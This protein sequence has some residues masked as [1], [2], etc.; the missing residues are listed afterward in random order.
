MAD[1]PEIKHI[2][3]AEDE[4]C[5][6]LEAMRAY[7]DGKLSAAARHQVERHLL[8]CE[9]CSLAIEGIADQ[10]DEVIEAGAA[11]IS[12]EAW[13]RVQ[14]KSKRRV[15]Y[16]WLSAAASV[17]LLVAV[18]W[19]LLAPP[20]DAKMQEVFSEMIEA[21]KAEDSVLNQDIAQARPLEGATTEDL[22]SES[23]P[24]SEAPLPPVPAEPK[25]NTLTL[26]QKVQQD[27]PVS[28]GKEMA[29]GSTANTYKLSEGPGTTKDAIQYSAAP[30]AKPTISRS[31][32]VDEAVISSAEQEESANDLDGTVFISDDAVQRDRKSLE[33]KAIPSNTIEKRSVAERQKPKAIPSK[34]S[35]GVA[36]NPAPGSTAVVVAN[37][38]KEEDAQLGDAPDLEAITIGAA[39]A[40]RVAMDSMSMNLAYPKSSFDQGMEAYGRQDF[41]N[42]ATQLRAAAAQTPSNFQ[43]H[44]YAATSFLNIGQPE[45]A[46]F[47]LDRILAQAP[48]AYTEDA[49]WYKALAYLKMND[50]ATAKKQLTKV[51]DAKGKH[52]A[53]AKSSLEKL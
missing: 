30:V 41:V 1:A 39:S 49:E 26:P 23:Q 34:K 21:S 25:P 22:P 18:G 20:S 32:S 17:M 12:I 5:L 44:L 15:A 2:F 31:I 35:A 10:S 19:A 45:A 52:S 51:K 43:A 47:H 24:V 46:L 16:I 53:K 13:G 36:K 50:A 48:N 29:K 37:Q 9:L 3:S 27:V 4:D 11:S 40:P 14:A 8:N 28:A 42:A 6:S 38:A 7:Q 33:V